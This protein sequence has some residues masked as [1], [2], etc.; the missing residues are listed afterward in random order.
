MEI[1]AASSCLSRL[2]P[3]QVTLSRLPKTLSTQGAL[4]DQLLS[5][6]NY[7]TS[8]RTILTY[9]PSTASGIPFAWSQLD[10][11]QQAALNTDISGTIDH[12]GQARLAYLRGSNVDEGQGNGFRVRAHRLGDF[13]DSD[14][15]FVGPPALPDEVDANFNDPTQTNAYVQFRDNPTN[16]NRT[17][18]ILIGGNDGML[19]IFN[20][21]NPYD[22]ATG[23]GDPRPARRSGLPA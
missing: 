13:I 2:I 10:A 19:H 6:S 21:N 14:P 16:H 8:V 3:L 12:L 23:Q 18:M 11:A 20:A 5:D 1:G 9:K 15:F 7:D 22:P 4:L 17:K